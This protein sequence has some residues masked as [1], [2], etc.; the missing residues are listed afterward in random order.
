MIKIESPSSNN[1]E[2]IESLKEDLL[3]LREKATWSAEE[4]ELINRAFEAVET[5]PSLLETQDLKS[6]LIL[7]QAQE[8]IANQDA[9]A[10]EL[11]ELNLPGLQIEIP[12]ELREFVRPKNAFQRNGTSN[13]QGTAADVLSILE[14]IRPTAPEYR[15]DTKSTK[16]TDSIK[17]RQNRR[18]CNKNLSCI[19]SD[20]S[21]PNDFD[22]IA[23]D[24]VGPEWRTRGTIS[25]EKERQLVLGAL[26]NK[27]AESFSQA[28]WREWL[29]KHENLNLILYLLS[30]TIQTKTEFVLRSKDFKDMHWGNPEAAFSI[31]METLYGNG[32]SHGLLFNFDPT[33]LKSDGS[34]NSLRKYLNDLFV[35]RLYDHARKEL[36]SKA[37]KSYQ[38]E[39]LKLSEQLFFHDHH[40]K[41]SKDYDTEA[42]LPYFNSALKT[43]GHWRGAAEDSQKYAPW[44]IDALQSLL[45]KKRQH[46]HTLSN[47]QSAST[48]GEEL[49][50]SSYMDLLQHDLV[51][52][53]E[54]TIRIERQD[55]IRHVLK[56]LDKRSRLIMQLYYIEGHTMMEIARS[57][58]LTES[59]VCQIHATALTKLKSRI[60]P[61]A[62]IL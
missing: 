2:L 25:A 16:S 41:P 48:V 12:H 56:E 51:I 19:T 43:V 29:C 54:S 34:P 55:E 53:N 26:E 35:N 36:G 14:N 42:L 20:L 11:S 32:D 50:D 7:A 10:V 23:L 17:T 38:F 15:T 28:M 44:D 33:K 49:S 60:D 4:E 21:R 6:R 59:R 18:T 45:N 5:L 30:D 13:V 24:L 1:T 61:N 22:Q 8:W 37:R 46:T 58:A 40:R 52:E 47:L 39:V 3:S 62:K 57:L 27:I 31:T 9:L